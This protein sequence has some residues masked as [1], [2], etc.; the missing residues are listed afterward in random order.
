MFAYTGRRQTA[1]TPH[2]TQTHAAEEQCTSVQA[3]CNGAAG[4]QILHLA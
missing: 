2:M 1:V 3:L 4:L